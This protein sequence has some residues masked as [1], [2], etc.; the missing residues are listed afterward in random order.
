MTI[1]TETILLKLIEELKV[2]TKETN[3]RLTSIEVNQARL[4]GKID[5]QKC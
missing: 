5:T 3:Q 2:E 1:E 4:E